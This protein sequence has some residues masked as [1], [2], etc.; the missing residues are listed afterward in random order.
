M[1]PQRRARGAS[2]DLRRASNPPDEAPSSGEGLP[3]ES[4][5]VESVS[6]LILGEEGGSVGEMACLLIR[7]ARLQEP[8][9]DENSDQD[10]R[11]NDQP[12]E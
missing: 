5:S 7:G 2:A 12:G 4:A 6:G 1:N 8:D 3:V 11:K 9:H 10:D